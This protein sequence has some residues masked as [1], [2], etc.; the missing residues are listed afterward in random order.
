MAFQT[1]PSKERRVNGRLHDEMTPTGTP[2]TPAAWGD[3]AAS[4]V[5]VSLPTLSLMSWNVWFDKFQ[6]ST[7]YSEIFRLVLVMQPDIVCFQEATPTFIQMLVL[8]GLLEHYDCSDNGNGQTVIPYGV[9]SLARKHLHARFFYVDF[10][11]RMF[12]KLL[13]THLTLTGGQRLAVGNVHLESLANRRVREAQLRIASEIL[14]SFEHS[15]LC[16]DF[17]FC[18]YQNYDGS[19]DLENYNLSQILPYMRDLWPTLYGTEEEQYTFDGAVNRLVA[20]KEE[21]MRYDRICFFSTDERFRP[22]FMQVLD[23]PVCYQG[24]PDCLSV[25]GF[26]VAETLGGSYP[27]FPSDHYGLFGRFVSGPTISGPPL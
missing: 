17:N 2:D 27:I 20:D 21:R 5:E 1:P 11:S 7:R 8:S 19:I 13:V 22:D 25:D 15:L 24:Q 14:K 23:Q 10:P 4:S 16:G 9:V 12:R 6:Q 3:L 26:A 18:S